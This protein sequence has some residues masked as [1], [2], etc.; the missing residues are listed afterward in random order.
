MRWCSFKALILV[1]GCYG[2]GSVAEWSLSGYTGWSH[3]TAPIGKDI[4]TQLQEYARGLVNGWS[5]GLGIDRIGE[6]GLGLGL[7]VD[8]A[9]WRHSAP[10]VGLVDADGEAGTYALEDR[11]GTTFI[12]GGLRLRHGG[13]NGLALCTDASLGYVHYRHAS[14]IDTERLHLEG[15]NIAFRFRFALEHPITDRMRFFT[16]FNYLHA[17]VETLKVDD[18]EGSRW[19]VLWERDLLLHRLDVSAGLRFLL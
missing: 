10:A 13:G 3:R 2:Q 6:R 4:S 5:A 19:V 16:A 8:H 18:S 12:G 1:T 7:E 14:R 15:G 11:V 17:R 9:W